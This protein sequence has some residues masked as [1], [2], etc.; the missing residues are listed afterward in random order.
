M[1]V[2]YHY[3]SVD[4]GVRTVR[5]AKGFGFVRIYKYKPKSLIPIGLEIEEGEIGE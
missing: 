5:G 4:P 2:D 3:H 1:E